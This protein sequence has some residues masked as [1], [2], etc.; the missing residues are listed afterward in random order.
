MAK[1]MMCLRAVRLSMLRIS[2]VGFLLRTKRFSECGLSCLHPG[3]TGE[4]PRGTETTGLLHLLT[5][6]Q[7][8]NQKRDTVNIWVTR[9][10]WHEAKSGQIICSA[11]HGT[12]SGGDRVDVAI[13]LLVTPR[14]IANHRLPC[15]YR[16]RFRICV[17]LLSL[18]NSGYGWGLRS[19]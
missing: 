17:L 14:N 16:F 18:L 4:W 10:A 3:V 11:T 8:L 5:E 2:K 13:H 7:S 6:C 9:L 15:R 12:G 19:C 1:L